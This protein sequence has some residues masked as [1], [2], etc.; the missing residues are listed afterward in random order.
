M[1]DRTISSDSKAAS[2]RGSSDTMLLPAQRALSGLSIL[3]ALLSGLGKATASVE[4]PS[5]KVFNLT[6]EKQTPRHT[7]LANRLRRRQK[8]FSVNIDNEDIAY[9]KF[10]SN[11]MM[12]TLMAIFKVSR[13]YK[14]WYS[15][16]A[17]PGAAGHG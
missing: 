14:Y 3:A 7:P 12:L 8:A 2:F 13:Q 10:F 11:T 4:A 15:T 6:F 9:R 5:P 1:T 16:P 17:V